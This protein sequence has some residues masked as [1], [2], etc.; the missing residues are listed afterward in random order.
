MS[1]PSVLI[2][3]AGIVGAAIAYRLAQAGQRVTVLERHG[4]PAE[5]VTA[6]SY[7]WVNTVMINPV[8][9]GAHYSQRLTAFAKHHALN[10]ALGGRLFGK[11]VGSL[12]WR[13]S[14]TETAAHAR[15][16]QDHG[17]DVSLVDGEALRELLPRVKTPPPVAIHAAGDLALNTRHVTGTLLAAAEQHGATVHMGTTT[18]AII[19]EGGRI[20]AVETDQGRQSC[21]VCIVAAGLDSTSLLATFGLGEVVEASP[22]ALVTI[23]GASG[24]PRTETLPTMPVMV[25]CPTLEARFNDHDTLV[26]VTGVGDLATWEDTPAA[27]DAI[28][29]RVLGDARSVLTGLDKASVARVQVGYRPLPVG[30]E[31]LIGPVEGVD[32]LY[33][34]IAH[35]GVIL[36][37]E[38]AETIRDLILS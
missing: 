1:G 19:V 16:H 10:D 22:V 27:R 6:A 31:N 29:E 20:V 7:G 28:G 37:P 15:L 14:E 32:G 2:I 33:A 18:Q 8:D 12:V 34:A 25:R 5:G 9:P 36:A 24:P 35:P 26:A 3:G 11:A 17:S 23:A 13:Q 4:A 21:D 30:G 38:I